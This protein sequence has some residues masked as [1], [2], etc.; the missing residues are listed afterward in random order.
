MI[1]N[2]KIYMKKLHFTTLLFAFA[3]VGAHAAG[4]D[5]PYYLPGEG[6]Y[7]VGLSSTTLKPA[8]SEPTIVTQAYQS[9]LQLINTELASIKAGT[10]TYNLAERISEDGT[11]LD[12]VSFMGV[13]NAYDLTVRDMGG[14]SYQLGD[15]SPNKKWFNTRILAAQPDWKG[16]H[17]LPL[18]MYDQ[19]DCPVSYAPD[20]RLAAR[21]YDAVTVNFSNPHEGLVVTDVNFPVVCAPDNNSRTC[22]HITLNVW[23]D[24]HTEIVEGY[25]DYIAIN[26]LT[27]VGTDGD[28]AIYSLAT[29]F[30]EKRIVLASPFDITIE[31]FASDGAHLWLP[32]AVDHTGIY[33]SHTSYAAPSA[34]TSDIDATDPSSDAVVNIEG[35]FNYVGTW[36]WWDGKHERGEVVSSA[37]LVQVYYDPADP[38]WPGDYFMGE[39]AFPVECTFGAQD[40]TI[41]AMP[42][43]INA[44][45]YDES[46]WD[47]Y[48]CVQITLSA[49]ALP[50]DMTGRSSKVILATSE[51]ASFYTIYVRQ[52][53]AWF[54]MDET[55]GITTPLCPTPSVADGAFYD[56]KGRRIEAPRKGQPYI[57]GGKTYID[58]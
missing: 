42:E 46:Q 53:S 14:S 19:W 1:T 23:N 58:F 26:T 6:M 4:Y 29:N 38:D 12:L 45:S 22:L 31:G 36:G 27:Q 20:A 47:E 17:T 34:S 10:K 39:V 3:A 57:C 21:A 2:Q 48:G 9:R 44:V 5:E 41:Y 40:L 35:Y 7:L 49:D 50:S 28:N 54:D 56:L 24:D 18:A 51:L 52:G 30:G 43:W 13:G 11:D 32:Q 8:V 25:E 15:N 33:P 55:E 37:D 16:H